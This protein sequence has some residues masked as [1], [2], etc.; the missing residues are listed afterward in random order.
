VA[1]LVRG[2][3]HDAV[4]LRE[5]RGR[6]GAQLGREPVVRVGVAGELLPAAGRRERGVLPALEVGDVA[7]D[8]AAQRIDLRT[9]GGLRGLQAGHAALVGDDRGVGE[10]DDVRP[11]L[12]RG[13]DGGEQVIHGGEGEARGPAG[14]CRRETGQ[15]QETCGSRGDP[16]ADSEGY[17]HMTLHH[18]LSGPAAGCVSRATGTT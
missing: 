5:L 11:R 15:Q 1:D 18:R 17:C 12:G 8:V 16:A 2:D 7:D 6:G 9:L 3:G 10:L 13:L 14:R 4:G